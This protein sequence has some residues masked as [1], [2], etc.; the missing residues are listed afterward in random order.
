MSSCL[1]GQHTQTPRL[2][3]GDCWPARPGG[4]CWQH[5]QPKVSWTKAGLQA[6]HRTPTNRL[7][8]GRRAHARIMAHALFT[9]FDVPLMIDV[10]GNK[11]SGAQVS[12]ILT[13]V[14]H[15]LFSFWERAVSLQNKSEMNVRQKLE[16]R[17]IFKTFCAVASS[18]SAHN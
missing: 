17:K 7:G 1:W 11:R 2:A 9:T 18:G 16:T 4:L 12:H 8:S 15:R 6:D 14:Y 10:L 5:N 13:H 3:D